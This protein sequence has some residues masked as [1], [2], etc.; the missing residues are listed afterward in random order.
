VASA[1]GL[2]CKSKALSSNNNNNNNNDNDD[3]DHLCGTV[4]FTMLL[5]QV[6]LC[7]VSQTLSLWDRYHAEH[8]IYYF[9]EAK[10]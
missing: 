4:T 5:P 2:L 3:N 8:V 7:P 9:T 6:S 10:F 1:E